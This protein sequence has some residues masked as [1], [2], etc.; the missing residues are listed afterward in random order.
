[1]EDVLDVYARP[2]NA[3]RPVICMDETSKQLLAD[4]REPLPMQPGQPQ[5][6]DHEYQRQGVANLF[7]FF[8]PLAGQR[9]VGVTD[10]R[11]RCDWAEAMRKVADVHYP[12]AE[13]I[14]VVLD[15]LNTHDAASFYEAF[16]PAE[17]H[18]LANRFEFH[19]TPKHGSWLNMAEIEFSVLGRQVLNRRI[20]DQA[21]LKA[22]VVAWQQERNRKAVKVDW[23]FTTADA[24]IKLKYLYPKIQD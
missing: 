3:L 12:D 8:E 21:K 23:H 10:R 4:T 5:R 7:L 9:H 22:E 16:S 19:H 11:T 24:R 14:V 6:I 2:Y 1:M 18:R 15:N 20:P 17:A 13:C